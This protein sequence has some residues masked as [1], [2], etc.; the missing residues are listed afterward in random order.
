MVWMDTEMIDGRKC[1]HYI[2]RNVGVEYTSTVSIGHKHSKMDI[3]R[4]S[5]HSHLPYLW[6]TESPQTFLHNWHLCSMHHFSTCLLV[7]LKTEAVSSSKPSEQSTV[8]FVYSTA[9]LIL[10]VLPLRRTL[11]TELRQLNPSSFHSQHIHITSTL[12]DLQHTSKWP[13]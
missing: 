1:A 6:M 8:Q 9:Q 11:W 7:T 12:I 5:S 2:R 4:A 3:C 13:W 10:L